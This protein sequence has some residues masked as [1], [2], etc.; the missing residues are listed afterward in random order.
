MLNKPRNG[1]CSRELARPQSTWNIGA[2]RKDNKA[3][4]FCCSFHKGCSCTGEETVSKRMW[5][6]CAWILLGSE[7]STMALRTYWVTPPKPMYLPWEWIL[8]PGLFFLC[9]ASLQMLVEMNVQLFVCL[10]PTMSDCT[11]WPC[12]VWLVHDFS[13]WN[14]FVFI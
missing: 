9:T 3:W 12:C 6:R 13:A 14:N 1:C 8:A 4:S 2:G 11:L 5:F 7:R 10:E